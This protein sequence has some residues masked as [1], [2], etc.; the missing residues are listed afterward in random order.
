M[1]ITY[2]LIIPKIKNEWF[3]EDSKMTSTSHFLINLIGI[4][5]LFLIVQFWLNRLHQ[6][7]LVNEI[8][9][10]L[11][12]S[13]TVVLCMLFPFHISGGIIFNL[14]LIPFVLGCLYTHK[15]T[16]IWLTILII[17]F[18][19][20]YGLKFSWFACVSLI[21]FYLIITKLK[22]FYNNLPMLKKIISSGILMFFMSIWIIVGVKLLF[23]VPITMELFFSYSLIQS[24]GILL[25]VYI[26]EAN[27][28]KQSLLD[29]VIRM[30]KVEVVSHLAASISHEVRNP[31]TTSRGFLQLVNEL[32]DI[33]AV[34]KGYIEI[35]IEELDRAESIIRNYL[36]FAKP[37]PE[38]IENLNLKNEIDK[39]INI[40]LPLAH[41]NIVEL[42]SKTENCYIKGNAGLFQQV[43]V[44]ILKNAIDAMPS[45]GNISI[46]GTVENS[47]AKVLIKDN[48]VGMN[49][50][51]IKRL[52]E[53]YFSTKE[54]KGTGLGMMVV[55]RVIESMNGSIH[56]ESEQGKGTEIA[57][58]FPLSPLA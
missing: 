5:I 7:P 40:I 28:E 35:A 33:P 53:P 55:F 52:G 12:L 11:S 51:Q 58:T 30:E 34:Q 24:F 56:I 26:M 15:F 50:L 6:N 48:G 20:T 13:A 44:N 8:V 4:L 3:E 42:S 32:D 41:M 54:I 38:E 22:S 2:N 14:R 18:R 19:L 10:G 43:L 45:G 16:S 36:T 27:K 31:L 39:A 1:M 37:A 25:I 57:L 47:F 49:D 46:I 21:I 23:H 17:G 9:M 29:K